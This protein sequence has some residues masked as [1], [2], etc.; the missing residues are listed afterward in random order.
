MDNFE[1]HRETQVLAD[2]HSKFQLAKMVLESRNTGTGDPL[3]IGELSDGGETKAS[4]YVSLDEDCVDLFE[5]ATKVYIYCDD[6]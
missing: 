5:N 3:C 4:W 2:T 6:K 1:K